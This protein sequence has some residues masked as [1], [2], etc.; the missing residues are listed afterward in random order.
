MNTEIKITAKKR[1]T[2]MSTNLAVLL[3]ILG[4]FT[5]PHSQQFATLPN[6]AADPILG[7]SIVQTSIVEF[8]LAAGFMLYFCHPSLVKKTGVRQYLSFMLYSLILAAVQIMFVGLMLSTE[9]YSW[10]LEQHEKAYAPI[11]LI[12]FF[13]PTSLLLG[14]LLF[15]IS[16]ALGLMSGINSDVND[17]N[18]IKE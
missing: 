10:G 16:K 4:A 1:L 12:I 5:C 8:L 14:S 11:A 18:N 6:L 15:F 2:F 3:L 13:T 7:L 17:V 9:V